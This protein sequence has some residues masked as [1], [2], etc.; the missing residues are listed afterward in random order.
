MYQD[1][2]GIQ[3]VVIQVKKLMPSSKKH[4]CRA[5]KFESTQVKRLSKDSLE[6]CMVDVWGE[7]LP[8]MLSSRASVSF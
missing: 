7:R 5:I 6:I 1:Y 2:G 8:D 4:H 3:V